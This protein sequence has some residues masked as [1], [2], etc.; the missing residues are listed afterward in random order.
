MRV[1]LAA[2]VMSHSVAAGITTLCMLGSKL[3]ADAIHTAHFIDHFDKLFDT[4]NSSSL[5]SPNNYRRGITE[6]SHHVAFLKETVT[7]LETLTSLGKMAKLPCL[8][9]WKL[10]IN[11]LLC[12]WEDLHRNCGLKFLLTNRL[13]QDCLENFFSVIRGRGGHRDNPNAMQFRAEYRAV[14]VDTLFLQS[15][16]SNCKEDSDL[17]LLKLDSIT[18]AVRSNPGNWAATDNVAVDHMYAL[19]C[20]IQAISNT[21]PTFQIEEEEEEEEEETLFDPKSTNV[22]ITIPHI[23]DIQ[24]K[25][26]CT[27]IYR[28][29]VHKH[30]S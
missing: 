11:G 26:F 1:C 5:A 7:W 6:H 30:S 29:Y 21:P 14:A 3:N 10:S 22:Q 28:H 15:P 27:H 12:L 9:G 24:F 25:Q 23:S 16:T 4:F 19:P 17:Y 2:Q 20:D 18:S 8:E 13:N